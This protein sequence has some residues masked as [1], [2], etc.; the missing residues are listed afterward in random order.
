LEVGKRRPIRLE[1]EMYAPCRPRYRY[2]DSEEFAVD[3][4]EDTGVGGDDLNVLSKPYFPFYRDDAASLPKLDNF[5]F[6]NV[7]EFGAI[8]Q[9]V[10]WRAPNNTVWAVH[11]NPRVP[12]Y[13]D[14]IKEED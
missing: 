3:G 11:R 6:L 14:S 1:E 8:G 9:F 13:D 4:Y 7:V 2:Q 5:L 12:G 10:V